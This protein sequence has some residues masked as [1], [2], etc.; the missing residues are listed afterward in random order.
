[1][2]QQPPLPPPDPP[3]WTGLYNWPPQQRSNLF[4]RLFEWLRHGREKRKRSAASYIAHLEHENRQLWS[5]IQYIVEVEALIDVRRKAMD[6]C[7]CDACKQ[8][9]AEVHAMVLKISELVGS[10]DRVLFKLDAN[11]DF[12]KLTI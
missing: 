1:M 10:P 9:A 3:G 6:G 4:A 12:T 7:Q 2:Y 11:D 8:R 5:Q